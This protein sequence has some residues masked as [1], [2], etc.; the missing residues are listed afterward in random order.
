MD[1]FKRPVVE[2]VLPDLLVEVLSYVH[3]YT[4]SN[5]DTPRIHDIV[6]I[7]LPLQAPDVPE[8]SGIESIHGI[9]LPDPAHPVRE[10]TNIQLH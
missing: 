1:A 2:F 5:T 4:S 3:S 9:T 7:I 10:R 6:W 8:V